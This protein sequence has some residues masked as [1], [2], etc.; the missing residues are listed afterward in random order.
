MVPLRGRKPSIM[1]ESCCLGA[2]C[3]TGWR[4]LTPSLY[5]TSCNHKQS[6][7]GAMLSEGL[8]VNSLVF[9]MLLHQHVY[10]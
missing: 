10:T 6:M 4:R 2:I 3:T 8:Q 5:F 9:G 7:I 1:L